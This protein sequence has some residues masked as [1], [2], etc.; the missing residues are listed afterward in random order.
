MFRK[1]TKLL[2]SSFKFSEKFF[3]FGFERILM[4]DYKK[5]VNFWN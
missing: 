3:I 2:I 1:I 4:I 5:L